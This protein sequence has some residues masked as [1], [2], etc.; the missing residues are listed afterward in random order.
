MAREQNNVNACI[1]V[2]CPLTSIIE[3]QIAEASLLGINGTKNYKKIT[4][5][6]VGSLSR[7]FATR[8]VIAASPRASVSEVSLLAC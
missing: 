7:G 1:L 2:I 5:I 3:E 4:E 8:R 6:I